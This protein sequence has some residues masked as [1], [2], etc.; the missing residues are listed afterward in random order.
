M[1]FLVDTQLPPLLA[2]FLANKGY[3][4]LHTTHFENGH[5]F[6]DR[7]IIRIAIENELIIVTKDSDFTEYFMLHG[8]PPRVLLIE[9]GNISNR[10]LIWLFEKYLSEVLDAFQEESKMVIFRKEEVIGY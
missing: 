1:K 5:L 9:F 7:E 3:E 8:A 6:A 2:E 10:E 4:S